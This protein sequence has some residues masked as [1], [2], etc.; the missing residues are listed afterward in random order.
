MQS[1]ISH[2]RGTVFY[3]LIS[4]SSSKPCPIHLLRKIAEIIENMIFSLIF[5]TENMIFPSFAENQ[6]NMI[7]TLS[8][9]TKMLFIMQCCNSMFQ[10]ILP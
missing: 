9:F 10:I 5:V 4:F 3:H 2:P 7:F 1:Y 8:V 6:E